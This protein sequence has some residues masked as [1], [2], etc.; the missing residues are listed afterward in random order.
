M[1]FYQCTLKFNWHYFN[2]SVNQALESELGE[3]QQHLFVRLQVQHTI[4]VIIPSTK[5]NPGS[6]F[7]F[8]DVL[9]FYSSSVPAGYTI[10]F[11]CKMLYLIRISLCNFYCQKPFTHM[12][13]HTCFS[14]P[15]ILL[16]RTETSLQINLGHIVN[17]ST[18]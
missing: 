13:P 7:I 3:R 2:P 9:S 12:W 11:H 15:F 18:V 14:N 17:V 8:P 6:Y 10:L 1:N 5:L 4:G 16:I